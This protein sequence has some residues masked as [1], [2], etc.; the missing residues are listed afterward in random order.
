MIPANIECINCGS[1]KTNQTDIDC[2]SKSIIEKRVC[3]V[4]NS[5]HVNEYRLST[6]LETET[7]TEV[8]NDI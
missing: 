2:H 1:F 4:C 3:E 8:N 5:E 6:R 7:E